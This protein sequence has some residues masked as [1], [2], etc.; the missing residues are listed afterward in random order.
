MRCSILR[1]T[2][3]IRATGRCIFP[4]NHSCQR[5]LPANLVASTTPTR[6]KPSGRACEGK[7]PGHNIFSKAA[8]DRLS[9]GHPN[10]RTLLASGRCASCDSA[11]ENSALPLVTRGMSESPRLISDGSQEHFWGLLPERFHSRPRESQL[12][13][14]AVHSPGEH[15]ACDDDR[16]RNEKDSQRQ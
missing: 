5:A 9:L 14:G 10:A 7:L 2:P 6:G 15:H 13:M 4:Q 3:L 1:S 11:V 12:G 8:S 16:Y